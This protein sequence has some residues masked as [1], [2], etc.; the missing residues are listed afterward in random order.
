V[1]YMIVDNYIVW[2][3]ALHINEKDILICLL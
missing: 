1:W 2:Y 3:D